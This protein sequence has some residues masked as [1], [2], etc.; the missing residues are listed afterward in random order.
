MKWKLTTRMK[1]WI[2][3]AID[4]WGWGLGGVIGSFSFPAVWCFYAAVI[5]MCQ[6]LAEEPLDI[7]SFFFSFP[8]FVEKGVSLSA[9]CLGFCFNVLLVNL[10]HLWLISFLDMRCACGQVQHQQRQVVRSDRGWFSGWSAMATVCSL[11]CHVWGW[12]TTGHLGV[13]ARRLEPCAACYHSD[14]IYPG[15]FFK[16]VFGV[17]RFEV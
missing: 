5:S 3:G 16:L 12:C 2:S 10:F 14:I 9:A 17:F 1:L 8:F 7:S 13:D 6:I 11:C 4:V 15:L